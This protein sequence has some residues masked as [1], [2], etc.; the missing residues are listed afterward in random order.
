MDGETYKQKL[1]H[2]KGFAKLVQDLED[3]AAS[4]R[5]RR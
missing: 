2:E 3:E 1:L 5:G 4:N